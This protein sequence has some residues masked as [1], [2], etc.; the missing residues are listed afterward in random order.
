MAGT[1]LHSVKL[2]VALMVA[3]ALSLF[4]LPSFTRTIQAAGTTYYVSK[5]GTNVDGRSWA[6]AWNELNQINWGVVQP[7][8][9]ILLDG[10]SPQMVYTTSLTPGKSGSPGAPITIKLAPD[11]GRNGQV[12]IFGGRS[13]PLPECFARNTYVL[14]P[15]NANGITLSARS[16]IVVDGTKWHGISIHGNNSH[17]ISMDPSSTNDTIRNAEIYDNGTVITNGSA[18]WDGATATS[19]QPD[20]EGI[21][22][23]GTAN[24]FS[25]LDVHDNGQDAFQTGSAIHNITVDHSWLHNSRVHPDSAYSKGDV[26]FNYCRHSDGMQIYGGGVSDH[27]TFDHNIHGPGLL[28]GTLLGQSLSGGN[29]AQ[30]NYVTITNTLFIDGVNADIMGYATTNP[31]GWVIDHV[32]VFVNYPHTAV[33]GGYNHAIN[34]DGSGHTVSN[35]VIYQ[36][37]ITSSGVSWSNNCDWSLMSGSIPGATVA[38]PGFMSPP[39][40]ISLAAEASANYALSALSPCAGK[41]SSVTSAAQLAGSIAPLPTA[42]QTGVATAT[43]TNTPVA[44]ATSRPSVTATSTPKASAT[45]TATPKASATS[46]ATPKATATATPPP[47]NAPAFTM[48]GDSFAPNWRTA[49]W[50]ATVNPA[51]TSYVYSGSDAVA[52]TVTGRYGALSPVLTRGSF[53]TTPYSSIRFYINGETTGGQQVGLMLRI[54]SSQT[55]GK[56]VRINQYISGGSVKAN[57]WQQVDIPLSVLGVSAT[58]IDRLALQDVTGAAQPEVSVDQIEFR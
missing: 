5:T 22:V 47:G 44:T 7:G 21:H 3:L 35:S 38:N 24:T 36:G 2:R 6:S 37:R 51:S 41:G 14:Q 50:G 49:H 31:V 26:A 28:Q 10:G 23:G 34:L 27:L 9:T 45:S 12:V 18:S 33:V 15:A 54:Q 39:S 53:D 20:L 52:F 16:W 58:K 4:A 13:T 56:L 55:W 8:D 42:T 46:T 40:S 43:A 57:Q 29:S 1:A 11:A 48:Y 32:T 30:V 17:G 19:V 25:Y